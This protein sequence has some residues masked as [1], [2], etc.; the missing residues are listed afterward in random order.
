[1]IGS[2][3]NMAYFGWT[4]DGKA[5]GGAN[6]EAESLPVIY[7]PA[8]VNSLPFSFTQGKPVLII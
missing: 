6:R 1:M 3:L 5:P 8:L 7:I 4:L 2:D